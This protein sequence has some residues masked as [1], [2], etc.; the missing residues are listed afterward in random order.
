MKKK[1]LALCLLTALCIPV[2]CVEIFYDGTDV[3]RVEYSKKVAPSWLGQRADALIHDVFI[4]YGKSSHPINKLSN[5]DIRL[6]NKALQRF[7]VAKDELYIVM[8][9]SGLR[10][11]IFCVVIT[12]VQGK[13]YWWEWVGRESLQL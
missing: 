13:Q 1:I 2:F 8:I 12:G 5:T 9:T 11:Q 10:K 6:I 7:D 4:E 3:V